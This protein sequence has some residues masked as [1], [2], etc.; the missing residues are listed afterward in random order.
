MVCDAGLHGERIGIHNTCF[1]FVLLPGG[2][3]MA[4]LIAMHERISRR[5]NKLTMKK[6]KK[7]ITNIN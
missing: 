2:L 7:R 1:A 5:Q 6:V 4:L 3:V